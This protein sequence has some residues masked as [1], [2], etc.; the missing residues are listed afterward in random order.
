MPG[1]N[2]CLTCMARCS[3]R[4]TV[5]GIEDFSL[6]VDMIMADGIQKFFS[7]T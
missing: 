7:Q 4:S 2:L 3:R 5:V 6:M 1:M